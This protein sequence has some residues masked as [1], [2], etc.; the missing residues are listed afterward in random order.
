MIDRGV[1]DW[2][3]DTATS[4]NLVLTVPV[5]LLAGLVSFFSPCVV[6]LLPGYL[7]YM[8]GVAVTE[9]QTAR[10]RRIVAGA[11]LFVLGFSAVF[12]AGGALFGAVGQELLPYQREISI[13][14]GV[15]LIVMGLAFVGWVPV[16]QRDV[17]AHGV[18]SVGLLAA[19]LLGVVFGVGWT[20]CIGPTLTAVLALSANEATAGRGALL[21]LVYCIGLGLPFV[22]AALFVSRFL[23][24][25]GWVRRHQRAVAA[26]GGLLLAAT[27]VLLVTGWWQDLIISLQHWIVGFEVP[28]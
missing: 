15:L 22:L 24:L 20:P 25:T 11:L 6:P 9:L 4:G 2:F 14:A 19:P 18:R 17:R 1:T 5:A 12:V 27:G 21:T 13:V 16:L 3:L 23:R 28:L 8:S 7:S 26:V 10:R